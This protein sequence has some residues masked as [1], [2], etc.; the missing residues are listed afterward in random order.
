MK[1]TFISNLSR[2]ETIQEVCF[3]CATSITMIRKHYRVLIT[4]KKKAEAYFDIRPH[5]FALGIDQ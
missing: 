2:I 5:H 1:H 4:Q 3:Q